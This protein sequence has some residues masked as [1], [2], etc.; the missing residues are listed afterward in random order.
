MKIWFFCFVTKCIELNDL[1]VKN[2]LLV[3]EEASFIH[4]VY[5]LLGLCG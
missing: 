2:N 4:S 5:K 3:I 1:Y